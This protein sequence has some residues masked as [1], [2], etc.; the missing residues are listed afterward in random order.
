MQ[1][2]YVVLTNTTIGAFMSQLDANIV[3]ISLPTMLKP[4]QLP[5]T[6]VFDGIW[7]IM[8]YT[9]VTATTLLTIGRLGD[10]FGRVRLYNF[11]F[12]VFTVGSGLCSVAPDGTFLVFMRLVQGVGAALILS[13]NAAILT[14]AFPVTERGKALGI[15]QIAGV[16]G[17]ILGLVGGGFLTTLLGWRSIFWIN[18]APGI[19]ATVWAYMKLKDLG[20]RPV[21][22]RLDPLG[23]VLFGGGLLVF[24][25]GLTLSAITG[26][27]YD[28][29]LLM[30]GGLVTLGLF[31]F[32]E[33]RVKSP[34]I[35]VRLF[36]IRAF[37]AGAL[38]NLLTSISRSSF[39][40]ILVF[41]FQGVLLYSAL[42]SGILLL[43]FA[44]AF[45]IIGP[46]SGYLSDRIG[47]RRLTTFGM[48]LSAVSFLFFS[49]LPSG[50]PYTT[51]VLPMIL[52]GVGG[53]MF[54]APNVAAIM[55][56]VPPAQRGVASGVSS[57]LFSVGSLLSL[58]VLFAI[59]GES[60]PLSALQDIF[61][62]VA[63]P[64]GSLSIG[65]FV[66]AMHLAFIVMAVL[67]LLAAIPASQTGSRPKE[68]VI[69]R[70]ESFSG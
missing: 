40:L 52:T 14:D 46:L 33:A 2:K 10:I 47:P 34:M 4:S 32:V 22:E 6:T 53:G 8:G 38:A 21:G 43:P 1:Y 12:A 67:S 41:Y 24:L 59:F 61:A 51:L 44:I 42:E 28:K 68:T 9:L 7:I 19:F 54:F 18:L 45:V 64:S 25:L 15:N 31:A 56:S 65:L 63:P 70:N 20:P 27:S 23:N 17:S 57:T 39:S 66:D 50:V 62:G 16:A 11:G 3:L 36:R 58:G 37:A 55:N 5:G 49:T 69:Y 30:V 48:V 35:D 26:W 29:D 60:V 13:N